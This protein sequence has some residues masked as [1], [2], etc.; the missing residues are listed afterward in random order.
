MAWTEQC[1]TKNLRRQ[2]RSSRGNEV[3]T[4]EIH[5]GQQSCSCKGFTFHGKCKHL[6]ELRSS[7]CTW[8]SDVGPERQTPQQQME[9]T[10]P[11]C[12]GFSESVQVGH[13]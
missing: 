8:R 5:P 1:S 2:F 4:A 13:D 3:Y 6:T 11:R 10:C 9:G 12:G 7:V